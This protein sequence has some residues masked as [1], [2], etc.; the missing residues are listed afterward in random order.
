MNEFWN[1]INLI[2]VTCE[3]I[4]DEKILGAQSPNSFASFYVYYVFDFQRNPFTLLYLSDVFSFYD[5]LFWA[6]VY[7]LNLMISPS[8]L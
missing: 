1:V 7:I 3:S 6:G 8:P 5:E 4:D 2:S